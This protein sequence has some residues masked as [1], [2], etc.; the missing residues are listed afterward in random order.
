MTNCVKGNAGAGVETRG[1]F[2]QL[3]LVRPPRKLSRNEAR[4][5]AERQAAKLLRLRCALESPIPEQ[6]IIDLPR[7][8]VQAADLGSLS[9][10][11]HWDGAYW[12][13]AINRNHA[14]VRQRFTLAHEFAHILDAP[15]TRYV[16][17]E[18]AEEVADYFAASFLMPKRLIKRL[19]GDGIQD[20]RN[21]AR[22][23]NVSLAAMR[24][25]L[26]ELR[27]DELTDVPLSRGRCGGV[28]P[29]AAAQ[30]FFNKKE[31]HLGRALT[32]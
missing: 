14:H 25:R 2:T 19:W 1:I 32:Y 17:S 27:L 18:H 20:T 26:D 3:R 11:S 6:A 29:S 13:I 31:A 5:V 30:T 21:L 24:W 23:F 4:R 16:R 10:L 7:I 22:R 9:G 15:F 12:Q 28:M 8:R